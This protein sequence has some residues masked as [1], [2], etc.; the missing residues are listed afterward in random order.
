MPARNAKKSKKNDV[1]SLLKEDHKKVKALLEDMSSGED[2]DAAELKE[3]CEQVE[4]ELKAH[5]EVEEKLVYPIFKSQGEDE[6]DQELFFEATEEHE[7]V[8]LVMEHLKKAEPGSP[9]FHARARVLSELVRHHIKEEEKEMLP[10]LRKLVDE[11]QLEE[12]GSRVLE[13]KEQLQPE[14]A[15]HKQ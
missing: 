13:M 14:M 15:I 9:S 6:E 4:R 12:I 11:Q 3:L 2:S 10:R 1:V 5:T 8:D 7:I